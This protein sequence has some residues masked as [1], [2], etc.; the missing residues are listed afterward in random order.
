[1]KL[2]F[3]LHILPQEHKHDTWGYNGLGDY[4]MNSFMLCPRIGQS[5]IL[6]P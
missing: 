6:L 5:S 2:Y 3:Y 4:L 1:M